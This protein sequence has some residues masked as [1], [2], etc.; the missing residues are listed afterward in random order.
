MGE[1]SRAVQ[2]QLIPG[3]NRRDFDRSYWVL[4][5]SDPSSDAD[6]VRIAS[7]GLIFDDILRH[8]RARKAPDHLRLAPELLI[9]GAVAVVNDTHRRVIA[10][11]A[12]RVHIDPGIGGFSVPDMLE[13]TLENAMGQ[14]VHADEM[15]T[16][17]VDGLRYFLADV[18]SLAFEPDMSAQPGRSEIEAIAAEIKIAI[19]YHQLVDLWHECVSNGYEIVPRD[20]VL[21]FKPTKPELEASRVASTYR[22]SAQSIDRFMAFLRWWHYELDRE[23]KERLCEIRLVEDVSMVNDCVEHI[24]VGITGKVLE[25]RAGAIEEIL[26]LKAGPYGGMLDSVLR[27]LAGV[28]LIALVRGWQFVQSLAAALHDVSRRPREREESLWATAPVIRGPIFAAALAKALKVEHSEALSILE[29]LTFSG[30]RGRDPWAQPLVRFGDDFL[31]VI[32]CVLSVHLE[33]V[34]ESWMRQ[35]GLDLEERGPE[36]EKY[37]RQELLRYV[38]A[39]PVRGAVSVSSGAVRVIVPG[40]S[41][42]IDLAVIVGDVVLVAEIKCILWP[43]EASQIANYRARVEEG[44]RQLSRKLEFART[45][46]AEFREALLRAGCQVPSA[47]RVIGC[48]LTNSAVFAGFSIEDE[49]VVDLSLLG[50]F[51]S[52]SHFRRQ[53]WRRDA[54]QSQEIV[55]LFQ[56]AAE[57]AERLEAYIRDPMP[58]RTIKASLEERV[59]ESPFPMAPYEKLVTWSYVVDIDIHAGE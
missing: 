43:D 45:H 37:C 39:S 47:V 31:L 1:F 53:I 56:G 40:A 27:G 46:T 18:P 33:R 2:Q 13:P 3:P 22:R 19:D 11:Q 23:T 42:E 15:V 9:R 7:G 49:P 4:R 57:A 16:S 54:I 41:E 29:A 17:M 35:G 55:T 21:E 6:D 48:V 51:L 52:G 10:E 12:S 14:V 5:V 25:R 34:S 20:V 36:F 44:A 28:R 58:L 30:A 50:I 8:I 26:S 59:L 24:R 32:P 38:E